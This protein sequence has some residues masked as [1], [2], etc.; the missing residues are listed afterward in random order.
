MRL[1]QT[2]ALECDEALLTGESIP[3]EKRVDPIVAEEEVSP[4]DRINCAYSSTTVT[5]GKVTLQCHKILT[6][7]RDQGLS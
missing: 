7:Q 3:V 2:T 6:R 4:G 1:F 5:K